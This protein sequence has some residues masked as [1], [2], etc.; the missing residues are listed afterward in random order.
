MKQEERL[1]A[2]AAQREALEG[3]VQAQELAAEQRLDALDAALQVP[4]GSACLSG[5]LPY[6][7]ALSRPARFG[8][9]SSRS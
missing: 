5:W 3:R 8:P 4:G 6:T 9:S 7:C 1:R 2:V